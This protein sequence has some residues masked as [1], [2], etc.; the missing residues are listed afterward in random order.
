MPSPQHLDGIGIATHDS[1]SCSWAKRAYA[2]LCRW[3][4][5]PAGCALQSSEATRLHP[6][7]HAPTATMRGPCRHTASHTLSCR[8]QTI[9]FEGVLARTPARPPLTHLPHNP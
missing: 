8:D 3:C 7:W 1:G 6:A 4:F 9:Q 5:L 2:H